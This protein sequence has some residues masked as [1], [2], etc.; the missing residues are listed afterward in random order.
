MIQQDRHARF[1]GAT[2]LVEHG[3][4]CMGIAAG[5]IHE[6]G[7]IGIGLRFRLTRIR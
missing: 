2:D 5:F 3:C 7:A 4:K 1:G 6:V